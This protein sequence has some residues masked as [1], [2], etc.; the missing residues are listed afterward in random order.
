MAIGVI[1][2]ALGMA[3]ETGRLVAWRK[4]EGESVVAGEP[5]LDIETDKVILELESPGDGILAGV[6][7]EDGTEVPVGQIVDAVVA[8]VRG[9]RGGDSVVPE[10]ERAATSA[11]QGASS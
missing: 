5:L 3:Q 9:P 10:V 2:P 1:M 6:K 11:A 4:R 8:E 7:V